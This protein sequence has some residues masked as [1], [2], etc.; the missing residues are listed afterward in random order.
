ML[1]F[2]IFGIS[3]ITDLFSV[4][5]PHTVKTDLYLLEAGDNSMPCIISD[6]INYDVSQWVCKR[7]GM[8]PHCLSVSLWWIYSGPEHTLSAQRIDMFTVMT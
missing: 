4:K 7:C 1:K 2:N 8:A 5:P 6:G 3:A